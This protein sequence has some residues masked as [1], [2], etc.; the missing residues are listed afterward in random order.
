MEKQNKTNKP[1]KEMSD[2]EL[3]D[4]SKSI[5]PHILEKVERIYEP[6]LTKVEEESRVKVML[7]KERTLVINL[8][9]M[10]DFES[11]V[12]EGVDFNGHWRHVKVM[13]WAG[14]LEDQ[15]ELTLRDAGKLVPFKRF[16]QIAQALAKVFEIPDPLLAKSPD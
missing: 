9:T 16:P 10:D 2:E 11:V 8:N 15:P 6:K 14:L 13:V 4:I 12:G 1:I 7:D 3:N 5:P